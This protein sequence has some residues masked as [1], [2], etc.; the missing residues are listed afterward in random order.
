MI[1]GV[2]RRRGRAHAYRDSL[3]R[4]LARGPKRPSELTGWAW[5][6]VVR[7]TVT[8]F[9]DDELNDRAAALTYYGILSIFPGLL[10]LVAVLGLLGP[11]GH[12]A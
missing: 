10:V 9:I 5:F 1:G 3:I 7:R 8:E 11:L 2:A 12:H 6:G 4:L